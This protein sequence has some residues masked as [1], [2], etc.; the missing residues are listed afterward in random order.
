[1][2]LKLRTKKQKSQTSH[3]QK[4]F[5]SVS[6]IEVMPSDLWDN[7]TR[8]SWTSHSLGEVADCTLRAVI[9]L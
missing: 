9:Q 7:S 2:Y 8:N 4:P 1:M 5:S 3:Q 6:S